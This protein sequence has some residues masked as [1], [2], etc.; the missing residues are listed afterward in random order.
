MLL[1][2][3]QFRI[4]LCLHKSAM[5]AN[6]NRLIAANLHPLLCADLFLLD[7]SSY[8]ARGWEGDQIAF[9]R[10]SCQQLHRVTLLSVFCR[11]ESRTMSAAF[12]LN[13]CC[14]I[15]VAAAC[16]PA[17]PALLLLPSAALLELPAAAR[18]LRGCFTGLAVRLWPSCWLS[19]T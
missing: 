14:Q 4:H 16:A 3:V 1:R 13:L 15:Q 2:W 18:G 17:G 10:H 7:A 9:H 19:F 12:S 6:P 8:V 5:Q 11:Y